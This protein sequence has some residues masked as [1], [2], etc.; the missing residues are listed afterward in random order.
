MGAFGRRH[1]RQDFAQVITQRCYHRKDVL[2]ELALYFDGS[3]LVDTV[4]VT[5]AADLRSK[6]TAWST[7]RARRR[8][9]V[10]LTAHRSGHD[11]SGQALAG[12]RDCVGDATRT[13]SRISAASASTGENRTPS[14]WED[15]S[16]GNTRDPQRSRIEHGNN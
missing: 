11:R 14:R 5:I 13:W 15:G 7:R 16:A 12:E 4:R 6:S 8:T 9:F 2:L 1:G 3:W 10:T